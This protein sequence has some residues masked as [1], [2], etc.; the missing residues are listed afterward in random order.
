MRPANSSLAQQ[1]AVEIPAQA[2]RKVARHRL[3]LEHRLAGHQQ[4]AAH[5]HG[6]QQEQRAAVLRPQ[7][8]WLQRAQPVDDAAEHRKEQCLEDA[9]GGSQQCHQ[10]D[11]AA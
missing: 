5:Q 8:A 10:R 7:P 2:H 1:Q 3:V 6:G 9:D 4:R 11:V